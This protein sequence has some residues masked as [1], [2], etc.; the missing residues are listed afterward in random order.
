MSQPLFPVKRVSQSVFG[1]E[2]E[3]VLPGFEGTEHDPYLPTLI[4]GYTF[5]RLLVKDL[6]YLWLREVMLRKDHQPRRGMWLSGPKGC[7]KTTM[8]A[9]FFGRLGV[10]L[11]E[12][13]C[14]KHTTVADL[15]QTKA[16]APVMEEI[17]LPDGTK[18]MR[19]VGITIVPQDGP[20]ATAMRRGHPVVLHEADLV[21]PADFT[22]LND[23]IDRGLYVVPES[24]EVIR[25]ER[26]F[27]V[28]VTANT[29]GTG[30]AGGYAGTQVMNT[31]LM[32]RFIKGRL[33][34]GSEQ[35][36]LDILAQQFPDVDAAILRPCVKTMAAINAAF[37]SGTVGGQANVIAPVSPLSRRELID[38]V[39]MMVA[40]L[41][42][43]GPDFNPA[44]HAF[45]AVYLNGQPEETH[46]GLIKLAEVN[47]PVT[48]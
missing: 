39:E 12:V 35:E 8:I 31:A 27:C 2:P 19:P 5:P 4:P 38:W 44:M 25:A 18:K 14:N 36:E 43:A 33:D 11:I 42:L 20:V 45:E 10:P 47:L 32:S 22:G 41:T 3:K 1:Q 48:T 13:T 7:G 29:N 28:F 21:D 24:G 15:L 30:D 40:Q 16:T 17:E 34:Y 26:G 46:E 23:V 6:A 9:Q 37:Y